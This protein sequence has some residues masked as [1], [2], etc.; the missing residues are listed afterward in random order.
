MTGIWGALVEAWEELRIHKLR[1]LLSLIGVAVS[2]M[3]MTGVTAAG[4]MLQRVSEQ[5]SSSGGRPATFGVSLWPMSETADQD[6]FDAASAA[7]EDF[8]E[9]YQ[10]EGAARS[11]YANLPLV[12]GGYLADVPVMAVDQPWAEVAGVTPTGGR[13]F[14]PDDEG[15]LS[16]PI[17]VN[18][19]LLRLLGHEE[20]SAPF[21]V[22]IQGE[23]PTTATVIG[24]YPDVWQSESPEA[25]MLYESFTTWVG[26][27]SQ[28]DM[29]VPETRIW[30]DPALADELQYRLTTELSSIN[31]EDFQVD[32]Y[33]MDAFGQD[34]FM[35]T[36]RLVVT[37]IG[38]VVLGLSALN[39]LNIAIVTLRQRIREIG[40]RRALGASGRRVFFAILLESVVATGLAGVIGVVLSIIALKNVPVEAVYGDFPGLVR[41]GFPIS[42]AITGVL[43]SLFVGALCG[44]IP[45]IMAVRIRPIEAIRY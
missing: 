18:E 9:R 40:V 19:V 6:D 41:P 7:L 11:T 42:A 45:A 26:G 31:G 24:V 33:R 37:G 43:A 25:Y 8:I 38:L 13:W 27:G 29:M 22:E 4:E 34:D 16:P 39:L 32:V 15:M 10:V 17:V 3:A 23:R 36:F 14:G 21:T 44:L 5:L 1:V 30:I 2:V 28:T 20:W 12:V 35:A